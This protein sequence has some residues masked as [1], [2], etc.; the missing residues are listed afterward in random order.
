M[1]ND[2]DGDDD[3]DDVIMITMTKIKILIINARTECTGTLVRDISTVTDDNY[4]NCNKTA[5]KESH[6]RLLTAGNITRYLILIFAE[7]YGGNKLEQRN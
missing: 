7:S 6:F 4:I 5:Y 3:D 2:C 1:N